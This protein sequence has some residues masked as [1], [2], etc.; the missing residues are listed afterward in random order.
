M[1]GCE[2]SCV[3]SGVRGVVEERIGETTGQHVRWLYYD[4]RR[5]CWYNGSDFVCQMAYWD[6]DNEGNGT[7]LSWAGRHMINE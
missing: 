4:T 3:V 6:T 1:S 7:I 2:P 5:D